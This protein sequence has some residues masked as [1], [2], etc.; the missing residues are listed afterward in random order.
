MIRLEHFGVYI[1]VFGV[2]LLMETTPSIEREYER[3]PGIIRGILMLI[4]SYTVSPQRSQA[5]AEL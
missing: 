5:D 3:I 2:R 1:G 4:N